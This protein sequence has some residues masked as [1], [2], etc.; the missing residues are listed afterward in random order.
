VR[1]ADYGLS[2]KRELGLRVEWDFVDAPPA[3]Q[4]GP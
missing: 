1:P 4:G 3:G 2:D